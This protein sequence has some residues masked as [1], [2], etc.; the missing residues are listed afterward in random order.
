MPNWKEVLEEMA[1]EQTNGNS[2]PLDFVRRKYLARI[3]KLTGRNTIAYYS[4]WLQGRNSANVAVNDKDKIALMTTVNK[5]DRSRGLDLILHTPGG[6]LAAAESIVDYLYSI[7]GKNIRAVIP[8]IS[9][10]AG[11]MIAL[12]CREIMMGKQSNLGPIDPQMGGLPC[13]GILA[14][15]EAAK[16]D[17]QANPNNAVL[18]QAIIGKYHPT[19]LGSCQHAITW[20]E[21]LVEE[22]LNRNMCEGNPKTAELILKEFSDHNSNKSHSRHISIARC[23]AIGVSVID[24]ESDQNLQDA[25]LSTHHAYMITMQNSNIEKIVENHLGVAYVEQLP[26]STP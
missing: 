14:E 9:M 6:D 10:S 26:N 2:S 11:T 20:S 4:G 12:S 5:L 21:K 7:F 25:I 8:H 3:E 19:L 1:A 13:Q 18:W 15:F 24:M 17:I 22:W 23:K 16:L